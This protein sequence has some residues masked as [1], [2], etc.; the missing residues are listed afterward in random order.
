MPGALRICLTVGQI[1]QQL[2]EPIHRVVY[3]IKT[4]NIAPSGIAGH[5]RVFEEEHLEQ[6]AAALRDIDARQQRE[7]VDS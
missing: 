2:N 3:A 1:A 6:I 5:A 4:R 7:A